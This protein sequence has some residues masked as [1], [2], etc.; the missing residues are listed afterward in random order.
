VLG[1]VREPDAE[2]GKR[3]LDEDRLERRLDMLVVAARQHVVE[4]RVGE[5]QRRRNGRRGLHPDRAPRDAPAGSSEGCSERD[6]ESDPGD[7]PVL[8]R[9]P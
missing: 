4:P 9:V 7:V 3:D 2:E 6:V 1:V 8:A 5:Q